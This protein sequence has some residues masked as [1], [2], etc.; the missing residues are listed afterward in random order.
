MAI[1]SSRRSLASLRISD[2]RVVKSEPR[3]QSQMDSF[4]ASVESSQPS[5]ASTWREALSAWA[6]PDDIVN[7][8]DESPWIHPPQLFDIPPVITD[9]PSH[10]RA[11]EAVTTGGSVLD[12]GCGGGI[13]A[14]ALADKIQFAIGVDHQSEMLTMFSHNGVKR[15]IRTEVFEGFWP[16]VSP[17]VPK[18]DVATAHHV[19]YN[20][21]DIVPFLRAMNDHA[22]SRVVLELPTK[23]PLDNMSGLWQHFWNLS[24]PKE[25]TPET[26]MEVLR[27]MG[28]APNIEL[29]DGPMRSEVDVDQAAHFT[30]IRLC[31]KADRE[32]EVR[33]F[34]MSQGVEQT[35]SLATIWWDVN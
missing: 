5:A 9:S 14:F 12:I 16:A 2:A 35:R 30:R 31:L 24:R 34:L 19:V 15:G 20:V 27:E 22:K 17:A 33:D 4:L 23:H 25:P 28:I 3:N 7:Q 1:T 18:C 8:A 11:R 26:L 32:S 6:I 21:G 10:A 13:A 29:W